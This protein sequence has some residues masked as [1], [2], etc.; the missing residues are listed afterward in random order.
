GTAPLGSKKAQS[1]KSR[2]NN[3]PRSPSWKEL[4]SSTVPGYRNPVLILPCSRRDVANNGSTM[5]ALSE[6]AFRE[7]RHQVLGKVDYVIETSDEAAMQH[8]A[9]N[10][11][12]SMTAL[13]HSE[14]ARS[15]FFDGTFS[16]WIADRVGS[17]AD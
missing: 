15:P 9:L 2:K 5:T 12:Q 7:N 14:R 17:Q 4:Q 11:R 13:T 8:A 6:Y 1:R 16:V 10:T 3:I